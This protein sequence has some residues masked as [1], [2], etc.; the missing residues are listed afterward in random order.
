MSASGVILR[1]HN[2]TSDSQAVRPASPPAEFAAAVVI[3]PAIAAAET[4]SIDTP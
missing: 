1:R 2:A 3:A 4:G